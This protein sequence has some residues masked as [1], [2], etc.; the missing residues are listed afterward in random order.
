MI[1]RRV[2]TAPAEF[3]KKSD[4]LADNGDHGPMSQQDVI[5]SRAPE[6]HPQNLCGWSAVVIHEITRKRIVRTTDVRD[7]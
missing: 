1:S 2:T 4:A 6:M 5:G 7:P 3:P